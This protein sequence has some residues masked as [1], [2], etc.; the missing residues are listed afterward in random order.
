MPSVEPMDD[1]AALLALAASAS[2]LFTDALHTD[3]SHPHTP[4]MRNEGAPYVSLL[5]HAHRSIALCLFGV[6][7]QQRRS[8]H[9]V[10]LVSSV[11]SVEIQP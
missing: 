10:L 1:A 3:E 7:S 6:F 11:R 9:L 8:S 5:R 2:G 4:A